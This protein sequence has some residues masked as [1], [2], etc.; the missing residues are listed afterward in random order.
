[1]Q[2]PNRYA[3]VGG[4][5]ETLTDPTG[6]C[7]WCIAAIV[8]A[9]VGAAVSYGSQVVQNVQKSGFSAGAFTNVNVGD[10]A[11][12]AVVGAF[13][14]AGGA[15]LGGLVTGALAGVGLTGGGAVAASLAVQ[16]G[17]GAV[18]GAGGQMLSNVLNGQG[19]MNN[20]G[21]AALI[22]GATGLILGG[23]GEVLK[24]FRGFDV[25]NAGSGGSDSIESSSTRTGNWGNPDTLDDHFLRH[26]GDFGSSS[27]DEYSRSANDLYLNR[28]LYQVKVADNGVIRVYDPTTNSFGSYNP[29]GTT[30]TFFKPTDGQPYFDQQP[31]RSI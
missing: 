17:L 22:G 16:T 15:V 20:V 1:M 8:G 26:G 14:G 21:Q 24:S 5:P 25:G 18:T 10:I 11:K 31:G 28:E 30:K 27:A 23:T 29:D 9:V 2:G 13:V 19:I 4:N 6:H 12:A 3:Y 7:P